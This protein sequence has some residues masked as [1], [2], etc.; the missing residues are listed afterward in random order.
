MSLKRANSLAII[1]LAFG[2]S[3]FVGGWTG[4]K[5]LKGFGASLA[6]APY[7]KVFSD[8]EGL[9]TFASEFKIYTKS[10]EY[11]SWVKITPEVYGRLQGSYNRRNVYGAAIS[12]G[13]KLPEKMRREIF[14]YALK[15][16]GILREELKLPEGESY[17]VTIETKT[18]GREDKW[19]LASTEKEEIEY[20]RFKHP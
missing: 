9:E 7:P 16:P 4:L 10:G 18:R 15:T 2:L 20:K 1:I 19:I 8:V 14:S 17:V 3:Q 6:M 12:Y 5:P 11:W 13:P